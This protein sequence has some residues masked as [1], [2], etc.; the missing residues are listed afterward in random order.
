M[1]V[2]D[3]LWLLGIV[4]F[5]L[6]GFRRGALREFC[7]AV[8][9]VAGMAAALVLTPW[10]A[11]VVEE[12]STLPGSVVSAAA[13]ISIYSVINIVFGLVGVLLHRP[14]SRP[15]HLP[16]QLMGS[17]FGATKAVA[18]TAMM[19]LAAQILRLS[20]VVDTQIA[21][22]MVVRPV[23]ATARS[24]FTLHLPPSMSLDEP[25]HS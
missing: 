13:F 14:A 5:A 21:S 17:L 12:Q 3:V 2:A 19:V 24:L 16:F 11:S 22:S 9:F 23:V 25:R 10:L 20:P 15:S 8:G 6:R 18:V 4:A 7:G 1:N